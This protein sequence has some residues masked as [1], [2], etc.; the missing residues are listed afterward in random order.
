MR[1]DE[2]TAEL[3]GV[4]TYYRSA[5][6]VA[7]PQADPVA[8]PLVYLHGLPTSS[9]IWVPLLE[10]AGGIAPD[11]IGFG[12]SS[13][14]G[15][16]DYTLAGLARAVSQLLDHLGLARPALVG[17]DW[18]ALVALELARHRPVDRLVLI[19]PVPLTPEHEWTGLAKV[20]R[21]PVLGEL[22]M[23]ATTLG[24][25]VRRLRGAS[26]D[27][28]AWDQKA[29]TDAVWSQFDQGTQRAIL[30]LH[31]TT[32]PHH[33]T[34]IAQDL[35]TTP[36]VVLGE[37]DPWLSAGQATAVAELLAGQPPLATIPGTAHWPWLERP[38]AL[39]ALAAILEP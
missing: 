32:D 18:G 37:R 9:D 27:P 29:R 1:V 16:L 24:L 39:E 4:L 6:P 34:S 25:L 15:H 13:K 31:R 17:H 35:E 21:T 7:S 3:D 8:S 30:R 22:A 38:E 2:H 12:R 11:L 20:W 33:L 23:G 14:G 26:T 10:R 28:G 5:D 19:A 36:A